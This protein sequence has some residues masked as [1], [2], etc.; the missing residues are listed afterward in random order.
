MMP[1]I[2]HNILQSITLLAT[3]SR[4]LAEKTIAGLEVNEQHI[5]QVL[6]R[7]PIL[8]TVLNPL[9][10]YDKATE[11]VK[12]AAKEKKTIKQIVVEMGYLSDAEADR[13]LDPAKMTKPGFIAK[14]T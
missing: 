10:G 5:T 8:A 3:V 1:V 4:L 6:N 7:N 2:A 13:V 14:D 11:V 12:R 9:I